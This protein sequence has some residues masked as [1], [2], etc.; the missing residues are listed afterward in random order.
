MGVSFVLSG[1]W[2]AMLVGGALVEEELHHETGRLCCA[3]VRIGV[4]VI[5]CS[6]TRWRRRAAIRLVDERDAAD[7]DAARYLSNPIPIFAFFA[8][9]R[10][11]IFY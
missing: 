4:L 5:W 11:L 7:L 1:R 2:R 6:H 8:H 9:T 3:L 10:P